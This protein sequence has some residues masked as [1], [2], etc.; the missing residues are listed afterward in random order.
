MDRTYTREGMG[1]DLGDE[2]WAQGED[3]GMFL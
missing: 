2:W 3:L 1:D